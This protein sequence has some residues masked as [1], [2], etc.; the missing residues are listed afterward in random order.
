MYKMELLLLLLLSERKYVGEQS[1][2]GSVPI[3]PDQRHL[4]PEQFLHV[5]QPSRMAISPKATDQTKLTPE[6]FRVKQPHGGASE[7]P[8]PGPDEPGLRLR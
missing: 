3:D 2:L 4:L 5:V 8:P 6:M 7:C 1:P